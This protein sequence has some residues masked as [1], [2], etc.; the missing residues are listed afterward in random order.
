MKKQ[1]K[2]TVVE[3]DSFLGITSVSMEETPVGWEIT[4]EF[5]YKCRNNDVI[6]FVVEL[7]GKK[8]ISYTTV[9]ATTEDVVAATS[10]VIIL[11]KGEK[12]KFVL[13]GQL[14]KDKAVIAFSILNN[15]GE[16]I[17]S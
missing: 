1:Q 6:T 4:A 8:K 5:R 12:G 10:K 2:K 16:I 14:G 9:E 15:N 17:H 13:K 11:P 3:N 7:P